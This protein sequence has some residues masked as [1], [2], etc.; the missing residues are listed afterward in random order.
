[1]CDRA[2]YGSIFGKV[3]GRHGLGAKKGGNIHAA[4]NTL[5]RTARFEFFLNKKIT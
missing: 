2:R 3:L 1:M 4:T 5:A